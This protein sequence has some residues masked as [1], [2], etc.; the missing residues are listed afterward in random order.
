MEQQVPLFESLRQPLPFPP[1]LP[2]HYQTWAVQVQEQV[3]QPAYHT[4]AYIVQKYHSLPA[5]AV[6]KRSHF[7]LPG[8]NRFAR[9]PLCGLDKSIPTTDNQKVPIP[10]RAGFLAE[11]H[12]PFS[13]FVS[14]IGSKGI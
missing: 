8:Y 2:P 10:Y 6:S 13:L 9:A 7:V 14:Q 4:Q 12:D 1:F 3:A 5:T 11:I